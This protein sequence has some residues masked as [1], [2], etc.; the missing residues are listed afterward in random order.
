[1]GAVFFLLFA[2]SSFAAV[3]NPGDTIR[4][5]SAPGRNTGF[6]GGA[7]EIT[8]STSHSSWYTFCLEYNEHI[9]FGTNYIVDSVGPAA[10]N[11]GV[12]GGNPDFISSQT[13]YLYYQYATGGISG[14]SGPGT[15]DQQKALQYVFWWLEE[16]IP[17]LPTS[18]SPAV[19]A[20]ITQYKAIAEGALNG[21]FYGVRVV[22]PVIGTTASQS[23]LVYVPEAGA[24]LL[25]GTGLVGL[26]GYRRVRRMQ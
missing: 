17:A 24:L 10:I 25:F 21:Q 11:G 26:V 1:M 5:S 12:A 9:S 18:E 2:A 8:D 13:A 22:N 19:L 4:F 23:Q 7:F 20:F 3:V 6:S 16:E 15:G 14:L